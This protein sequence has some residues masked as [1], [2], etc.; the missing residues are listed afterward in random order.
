M[1][2]HMAGELVC[3]FEHDRVALPAISLVSNSSIITAWGNDVDFHDVFRRQVK[4]LGVPGDILIAF[5]TSGK[6][7]SI[8]LAMAQAKKQRL[9][10]IDFPR[11][12]DSTAHIQEYQ[13]H[14]MHEVCREVEKYFL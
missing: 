12:G 2:N 4:A 10:V 11:K 7:K 6:S 14:L 3:T 5:S 1:S 9:T 13:L 8:L